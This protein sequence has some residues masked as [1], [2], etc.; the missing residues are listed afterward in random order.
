MDLFIQVLDRP[1]NQWTWMFPP[2]TPP[3]QIFVHYLVSFLQTPPAY[4]MYGF[5]LGV[6][7]GFGV[8]VI[9]KRKV[10]KFP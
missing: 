8:G 7:A 1:D 5:A 2:G 4:F 9:T 6:V 10:N 3:L